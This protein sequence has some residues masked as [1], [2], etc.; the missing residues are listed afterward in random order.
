MIQ[1]P[2]KD[3]SKALKDVTREAREAEGT[4]IKKTRAI[5]AYDDA[6]SKG[7]ALTQ[8]LLRMAGEPEHAERLRPSAR[9]PGT[10][11]SDEAAPPPETGADGTNKP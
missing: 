6:F 5:A 8:A 9:R 4:L 7:V 10:L 1:G 3:L 11:E 2:A